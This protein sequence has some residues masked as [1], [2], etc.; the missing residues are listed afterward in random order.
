ME[1]SSWHGLDEIRH[2][3]IFGASYCAV[4]YNSLEPHPTEEEPLG[5]KFPGA[6]TWTEQDGKPNWVGYMV[7]KY[8][9]DRPAGRRPLVFDYAVGGDAVTG[10]HR[11]IHKEFL[12]FAGKKPEWAPWVASDT[13]F[14]TWV[15]INDCAFAKEDTVKPMIDRL[16]EE[17]Q[18]LYNAGGRNFLFVDLP[19]L[20]RSPAYRNKPFETETPPAY[21][22]WNTY[23]KDGIATFSSAH[24]GVTAMLFSSWDTFT[25]VLDN[26]IE[27]GFEPEVVGKRNG[28]LW[29]DH[30]HPTSAMHDWIARDMVAFLTSQ[31]PK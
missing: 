6:I 1:E 25:R 23:L 31:P 20:N 2:F 12:P 21:V 18:Y 28:P 15:G 14:I 22:L 10:V 9:A 30:L 13:L 16:F 7:S 24:P 26:P 3:V 8:L 17:Q 5:V 11:Q 19:P 27:Y 4:G 29:A